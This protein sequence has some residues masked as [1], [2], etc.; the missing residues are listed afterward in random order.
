MNGEGVN[1]DAGADATETGLDERMRKPFGNVTSRC[2][3]PVHP[4]SRPTKLWKVPPFDFK[5]A[6]CMLRRLIMIG[7]G[8]DAHG[9]IGYAQHDAG[10][11]A[12]G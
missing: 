9:N 8:C 1:I 5:R 10:S 7:R 4:A 11:T 3:S 12:S 6:Y 2:Q